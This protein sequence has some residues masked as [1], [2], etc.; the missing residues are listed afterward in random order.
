MALDPSV[1]QLIAR[2][3]EAFARNQYLPALANLQEVAA[4]Y[5]SFADVQNLIGLC[6]SLLGRPEEAVDAF[7]R[8]TETNAGYVEAHLNLAITLNDLGRFDEARAEFQAASEADEEKASGPFPSAAAARLANKHAELGD[9]YAEAGAPADAL[10]EYR[11]A[12]ELRPQ[13]LD[14]RNKLARTL[15]EVGQAEQAADELRE[16]VRLRPAFVAARSNLG[17]ALFRLERMEDAEN[18][19]QRCLQ[20]QPDNAQVSGYL[21]MLARRR[22]AGSEP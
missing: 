1:E 9:L 8:A 7:R 22:G 12:V 20:Q 4:R 19:W 2:G 14:I 15:I 10:R 17:L 18:E 6:L 3:K 13:F 5:P 16:V 21:G 11:R